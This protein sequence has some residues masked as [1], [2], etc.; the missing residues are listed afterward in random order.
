MMQSQ[1]YAN[2]SRLLV[3]VLVMYTKTDFHSKNQTAK[4]VNKYFGFLQYYCFV[5]IPYHSLQFSSMKQGMNRTHSNP[6]RF[7]VKQKE[8]LLFKPSR[9]GLPHARKETCVLVVERFVKVKV[10]RGQSICRWSKR[11][12]DK[13]RRITGCRWEC[14]G[15]RGPGIAGRR[16]VR[17]LIINWGGSGSIFRRG[18]SIFR[19]GWRPN[20]AA[21]VSGNTLDIQGAHCVHDPLVE[22]GHARV[23]PRGILGTSEPPGDDADHLVGGGGPGLGQQ[24]SA[25]VALTAVRIDAVGAELVVAHIL[26]HH[27]LT[28]AIRYVVDDR[29]AELVRNAAG[30]GRAKSDHRHGL[31]GFRDGGFAELGVLDV[32][33]WSVEFVYGN[34]VV[35]GVRVVGGVDH[36]C[37]D[38]VPR[39][40]CLADGFPR[41][42]DVTQARG[43]NV[44]G[45]AGTSAVSGCQNERRS[46]QGATT[47]ETAVV[48]H[49]RE[50]RI[51]GWICNDIPIDDFRCPAQSPSEPAMFSLHGIDQFGG[52]DIS[53][54][55]RRGNGHSSS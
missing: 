7:R 54:C 22:M 9:N 28:G 21:E 33:D 29:F 35:D 8:G 53:F 31:A 39:P 49:E 50:V 5:L 13:I 41:G 4:A 11:R 44:K 6:L 20:V 52:Q 36:A 26:P 32:R 27:V 3:V 43:T 24:G 14:L 16:V 19:R 40:A 1:K 18:R 30:L 17:V 38:A 25:R 48:S 47:H 55:C 45:L 2:T 34:V 46:D 15:T 10:R 23:Y 42:A 37:L 12:V 51:L